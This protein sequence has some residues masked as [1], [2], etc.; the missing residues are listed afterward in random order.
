L[1]AFR[2]HVFTY[3][4]QSQRRNSDFKSLMRR[5]PEL[6]GQCE[7]QINT[8]HRVA[9]QGLAAE[10]TPTLIMS[11]APKCSDTPW[12]YGLYVNP[13]SAEDS[14]EH[15]LGWADLEGPP[16]ADF[17]DIMYIPLTECAAK[18]SGFQRMLAEMIVSIYFER[19][20]CLLIRLPLP[21]FEL[22]ERLRIALDG[23]RATGVQLPQARSKN[24][25]FVSDD[26]P[27]AALQNFGGR[28]TMIMHQT[29][30]FWRYSPALY[31]KAEQVIVHL[32]ADAK[33]PSEGA[34]KLLTEAFGQ[35][36]RFVAARA[37]EGDWVSE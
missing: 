22:T 10:P 13:H 21:G 26:M 37:A 34:K 8:F 32:D 19:R 1:P 4:L 30:E 17:K 29:F 11:P 2:N 12:F 14:I 28:L 20:K 33:R 35:P 27:D 18:D 24:I 15:M 25:F 9:S 7:T 31:V 16:L 36:P 23:L 3:G 6:L 5:A